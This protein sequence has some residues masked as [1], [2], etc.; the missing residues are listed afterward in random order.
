MILSTN[1]AGQ[2]VYREITE[3]DDIVR[4]YEGGAKVHVSTKEFREQVAK[5]RLDEEDPQ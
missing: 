5:L 3:D 2:M 4:W 1:M